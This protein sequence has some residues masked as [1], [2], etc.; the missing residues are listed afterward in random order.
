MIVVSDTTAISNLL[1]ISQADLLCQLFGRICIPPA[2]CAELLAYHAEIP[3]WLEVLTVNDL[4]KVEQYCWSVHRGEAEALAL[5]LQMQPDWLL[6]DDSDGRKLA[7][8]EGAP[9]IGLMGVLLLAKQA[10]LIPSVRPIMDALM[11][12]AGFF[13]ANSVRTA[14]LSAAGE[15]DSP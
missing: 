8:A 15:L 9:V 5:A 1:K 3:D 10:A 11:S 2:V 7:K 13:L 14:V 12:K 4:A 6:I